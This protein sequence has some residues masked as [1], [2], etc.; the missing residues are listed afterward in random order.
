MSKIAEDKKFITT[1]ELKNMGYTYYKIDKLEKVGILSRIN[2]STYENLEYKGDENDFFS[3]EA[4]VPNGVICLM[5]AAR[6]YGLTNFLP[7]AVDVAIERK[8]KVNTLPEWPE[9]RIFYFSQSRMDIGVKKIYEGKNCF[10]IF[11]IEKTVVDIIYYR[12][13][14]GIE[15]TS[16]VFKNYLKRRDRQIDRIYAYAKRLRCEKVVRTYL[17][18]LI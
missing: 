16:E 3:A 7:D 2:R 4:Y 10:H 13:K 18:V 17:E 5:S 12:N 15:E 11:D 1:T 9:I 14:I 8:K 6:Y